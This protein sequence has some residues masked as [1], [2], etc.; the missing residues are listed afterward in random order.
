M[1]NPYLKQKNNSTTYLIDWILYT[2]IFLVILLPFLNHGW[3]K[4]GSIALV[5]G[6]FAGILNRFFREYYAFIDERKRN[7]EYAIKNI[8]NRVRGEQHDP[9]SIEYVED[10][11]PNFIDRSIPDKDYK[12][13][14]DKP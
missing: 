2:V 14:P 3:M 8:G 7:Q 12:K 5:L 1:N 9:G 10:Y 13:S 4:V 6:F 11:K